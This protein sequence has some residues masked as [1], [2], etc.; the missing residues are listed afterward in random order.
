V[1]RF[2]LNLNR[3]ARFSRPSSKFA[4]ILRAAAAPQFSTRRSIS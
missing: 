2:Q 3:Q 4:V 1:K